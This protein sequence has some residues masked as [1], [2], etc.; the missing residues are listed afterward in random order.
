MRTTTPLKGSNSSHFE[1][2]PKVSCTQYAQ[3]TYFTLYLDE[4]FPQFA[5]PSLTF[6][7][8]FSRNGKCTAEGK[9]PLLSLRKPDCLT[10]ALQAQHQSQG[11]GYC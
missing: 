7:N 1:L 2:F 3:H 9:C 8:V 4:L 6:Q 10:A 11:L 5:R